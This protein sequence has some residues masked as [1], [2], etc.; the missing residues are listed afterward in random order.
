MRK[1]AWPIESISCL[2][3]ESSDV[4]EVLVGQAGPSISVA[5][6]L[7]RIGFRSMST[8]LALNYSTRLLDSGLEQSMGAH[9]RS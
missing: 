6:L 4:F 9:E 8:R 2:L 7:S 3:S 1:T 5:M